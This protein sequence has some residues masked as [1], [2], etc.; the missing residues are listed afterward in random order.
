MLEKL[1]AK[2]FEAVFQIMEN[3]FPSD[4]YRNCEEQ[5]RLFYD[6][7][8][9]VYGERDSFGAIIAFIATWIFDKFVFV[10]HF[11]VDGRFRGHG[12]GSDMLKELLHSCNIPICLEVELPENDV[13]ARRIEF[14]KRNGF[15]LNEYEYVQP[16]FSEDKK[17]IPLMIM[18]SSHKIDRE[19]FENIKSVLYKEVYG[20]K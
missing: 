12:K 16:P 1:T 5:R 15:C 20:V 9:C 8:Y 7:R 3:S 17:S 4:E 19:T 13:A 2:D 18:T 10:E 14:Y 11:A 6:P